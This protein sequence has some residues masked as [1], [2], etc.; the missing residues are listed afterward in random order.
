MSPKT[1]IF[2][3]W[4]RHSA[5]RACACANKTFVRFRSHRRSWLSSD[6]PPL[7]RRR[8][9][10]CDASPSVEHGCGAWLTQSSRDCAWFSGGGF[11]GCIH[12]MEGLLRSFLEVWEILFGS[13]LVAPRLLRD[14]LRSRR[15]FSFRRLLRR[16]LFPLC[17]VRPRLSVRLF[18]L[19]CRVVLP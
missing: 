18:L 15:L 10:G 16:T 8:G 13:A 2:W 6:R 1:S 7:F 3:S 12:A 17:S 14:G 19:L 4:S 9:P 11:A 5:S